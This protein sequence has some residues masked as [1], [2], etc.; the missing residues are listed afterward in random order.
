M[1]SLT[2]IVP[3]P[4]SRSTRPIGTGKRSLY[5]AQITGG[6]DAVRFF[7]SGNVENELGPISMPGIDVAL[8]GFDEGRRPRRVA[9]IR[10]RCSTRTF[11]ANLSGS[12]SPKLDMQVQ[13]AFIK[14]DYRLPQVDNNVNSFYYNAYTNQGH[15]YIVSGT[16]GLNYSGD[17]SS[18]GEPLARMGAVHAGGHLPA[19]A[20]SREFS[21]SSAAATA[22]WR[23]LAWL[24]DD[25]TVGV[26]FAADNTFTSPA[27]QRGSEFRN[28]AVG[29]RS[30]TVAT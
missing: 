28:A 25:G 11:R 26:D 16:N 30:P 3:D 20:R 2:S 27:P 21:G 1:D 8:P 17:Q 14:S 5:S 12:L 19:H 23:P 6:S 13:S 29:R 24:Q 15:N 7:I 22:N 18:I 9:A 4:R 10:K